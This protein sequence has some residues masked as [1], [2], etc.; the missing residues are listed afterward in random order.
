[1]IIIPKF[2]DLIFL[3]V[4]IYI[5][6]TYSDWLFTDFYKKTDFLNIFLQGYSTW[7]IILKFLFI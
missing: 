7:K 4:K 6:L 3:D 2:L 1:M 5:F